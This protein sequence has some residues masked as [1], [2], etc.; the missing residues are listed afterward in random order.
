MTTG[1]FI[2]SLSEKNGLTQSDVARGTRLSRQSLNH[3]TSGKRDL[4]LSQALR[5]E[6]FFSLRRGTLIEMQDNDRIQEHIKALRHSI[7]GK[8]MKI[9]AFWS[10]A[11]VTEESI[12]DEDMIEKT[13]IHLD[14][15]EISQ[16][17]EMFPHNYIK[18]VWIERMACQ[19]DYLHSL[20]MMIAQYYFNIR[21]PR[22]FLHKQEMARIKQLTNNA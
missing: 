11:D 7:C 3:I 2:L 22:R 5:L 18:K 15:A 10:F 13:F 19:G 20:N 21:N 4:T 14:M 1:K 9:N 8:L 6:S 12:S 17:F 16:L